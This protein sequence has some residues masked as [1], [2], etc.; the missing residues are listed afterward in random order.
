VIAG[1]VLRPAEAVID[2]A[3]EVLYLRGLY[4]NNA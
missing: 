3:R 1:D 2:C 4:A